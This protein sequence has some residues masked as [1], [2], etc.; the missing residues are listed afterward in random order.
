MKK[1]ISLIA[2]AALMLGSVGFTYAGEEGGGINTFQ[3]TPDGT[4]TGC[5]SGNFLNVPEN[6]DGVKVK[7]IAARAFENS[8]YEGISC[9][10][11]LTE[12]GDYAFAGSDVYM[13]DIP[14]SVTKI[15]EGAFRNCKNLEQIYFRGNANDIQFG[16]GCFEGAKN[17]QVNFNCETNDGELFEKIYLAKGNYEFDINKAHP[18]TDQDF[19][20]LTSADMS[21]RIPIFRCHVCDYIEISYPERVDLPF[22]DVAMNSWYYDY[23]NSSY[24][25]GVIKGKTAYSFE[26]NANM[27]CAEA[28]K[29]AASVHCVISGNKKVF[30]AKPG[31]KWYQPYV[32]YCYENYV[33]E[34]YISFDWD[35]AITRG[36]MAYL[37]SRADLS[38]GYLN[39]V[40]LTDIPD[41]YDTTPYAYDILDLYMMGIA[42]GDEFMYF[43]PDDNIKRSEAA[44]IVSRMIFPSIRVPIAVG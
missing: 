42:I 7:K 37:F 28:A 13:I 34:D 3:I 32:D 17:F 41:V 21:L 6:I 16:A 38:D 8:H 11:G 12:I 1:L 15:G 26:P 44:A 33:I 39:A 2:A 23:V 25:T 4:I 24:S 40:E 20:E 31:E 27:T 5:T 9:V 10:E 18:Y 29:I 35:K 19:D 43:K 22:Y 14:D 30:K 36:E